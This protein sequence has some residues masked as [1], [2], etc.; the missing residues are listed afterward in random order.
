MP[1]MTMF[2]EVDELQT[3]RDYLVEMGRRASRAEL[4]PILKEHFEPVVSAERSILGPHSKSGALMGSL[5]ARSGGGDRPGTMSVFS[6]PTATRRALK[7]AWSGGRAQQKRW[8][9]NITPGRGRKSVFYGGFVEHGHRIVKRGPDGQ[10]YDTGR[11]TAPVHFALGA[12]ESTG[13]AQ[14]EKAAQA[15]LQYILE[16]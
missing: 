6:A 7:L 3:L 14:A 16:S 9:S 2:F 10:L 11:R 13:E 5:K 8:A 15:I 1:T 12:M 4:L